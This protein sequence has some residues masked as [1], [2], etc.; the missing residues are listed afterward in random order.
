MEGKIQER[1]DDY[2]DLYGHSPTRPIKYFK[3]TDGYGWLCDKKVDPFQDFRKQGC[4]R[5]DEMAFPA[6]GR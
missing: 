1:I 4:W 2:T 3:D 6:G 5:C